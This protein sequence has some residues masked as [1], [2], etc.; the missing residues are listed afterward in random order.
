M[1][2]PLWN[3]SLLSCHS[4]LGPWRSPGPSSKPVSGRRRRGAEPHGA[5]AAAAASKPGQPLAAPD[6]PGETGSGRTWGHWL[7]VPVLRSEPRGGKNEFIRAAPASLKRWLC[8][9]RARPGGLRSLA[10]GTTSMECRRRHLLDPSLPHLGLWRAV[11][12]ERLPAPCPGLRRAGEACGWEGTGEQ[13][14]LPPLPP[15]PGPV[16][17]LGTC[18]ARP[19]TGQVGVRN[20]L[21][22]IPTSLCFPEVPSEVFEHFG[23]A[24]KRPAGWTAVPQE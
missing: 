18:K 8:A 12:A 14:W 21:Q 2:D 3:T 5:R 17:E 16:S 9:A 19:C 24:P 4:S 20:W 7:S 22:M 1:G 15:P 13:S 23:V 11:K 10:P 6:Y